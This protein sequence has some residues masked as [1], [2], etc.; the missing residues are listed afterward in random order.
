MS[1]ELQR[2]YLKEIK[3][4]IEN[5]DRIINNDG[6]KIRDE[7]LLNTYKALEIQSKNSYEINK[8]QLKSF[9]KN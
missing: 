6:D 1:I 3:K 2:Q 5:L 8:V 4:E 7:I 9:I